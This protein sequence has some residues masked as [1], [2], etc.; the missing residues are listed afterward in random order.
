MSD[1]STDIQL[2]ST[3]ARQLDLEQNQA[4]DGTVIFLNG[5]WGSGKTYFWK[6]TVHP[7]LQTKKCIYV[8]LFGV[9][10]VNDL[11]HKLLAAVLAGEH[12]ESIPSK[13]RNWIARLAP[14]FVNLFENWSGFKFDFDLFE[15]ISSKMPFVICF[16]DF[17][18]LPKDSSIEEI[19]GFINYLSEHKGFRNLIIMNEAEIK[20]EH[21]EAFNQL[22]EK[23][24]L[25]C[26]R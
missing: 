15:L 22:R 10:S 11:K 4:K 26:G 5:P 16:D 19:L 13:S 12:T 3:I 20:H 2:A 24:S 25:D 21:K 23:L 8:S 17:E 1:L 18:R 7:T 9:Q 6:K 14:S